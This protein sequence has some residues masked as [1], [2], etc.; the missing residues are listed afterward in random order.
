MACSRLL[1][2]AAD[3]LNAATMNRILPLAVLLLFACAEPQFGFRG[4]TELSNCRNVIDAELATGAA[5]RDVL[6]EELPNGDGVVTELGGELYGVPVSIFVSCYDNG[7]VSAVDY[8]AE[9]SD[10]ATSAAFYDR[11][12]QELSAIFPAPKE[13]STQESRSRTYH[14][15]DPAT[16]ILREALHGDMDYEVSL[17]VVPRPGEC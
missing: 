2:R 6:D 9:A 15:G 17:L 5:F 7:D 14:C 8:I 1:E 13:S 4:Y 12:S 3:D 10:G 11:L 16:V